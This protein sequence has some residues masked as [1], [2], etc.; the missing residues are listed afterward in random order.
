M[1]IIHVFIGDWTVRPKNKYGIENLWQTSQFFPDVITPK[2]TPENLN[3][4]IFYYY[5]TYL[6]Q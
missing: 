5:N 2:I 4:F 3:V 1:F 6:G